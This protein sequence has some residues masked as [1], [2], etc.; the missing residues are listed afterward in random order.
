M[1]ALDTGISRLGFGVR[2]ARHEVAR[3]F[4][5]FDANGGTL[6][7][8]EIAQRLLCNRQRPDVVEL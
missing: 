7:R 5:H 3:Y 8:Q 6:R 1:M 2:T 4:L